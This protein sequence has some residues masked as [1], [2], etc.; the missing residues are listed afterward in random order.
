M[1]GKMGR[2]V[3]VLCVL[4]ACLSLASA[5]R[6]QSSFPFELRAQVDKYTYTISNNASLTLNADGV[7]AP[8]SVRVT[9][10]YRGSSTVTIPWTPQLTGSAE[11][12]IASFGSV[13]LVVNPSESFSFEVRFVP[14]SSTQSAAQ[15]S[16]AYVE[17]A[18]QAGG[19]AV[20]GNIALGLAGTA[21][22]LSVYYYLQTELNVIPLSP[23][24]KLQ[25]PPTLINSTAIATVVIANRG[26]GAGTIK[27][28]SVNATAFKPIGIPLMPA[29]VAAS[30]TIQ[31]AI[32]Y[33]PTQI[34]TDTGTLEVG[35]ADRTIQVTLEGSCIAEKFLYKYE[36]GGVVSTVLPSEAVLFSPLQVGQTSRLGFTV[37]NAGTSAGTVT[38][39]GVADTQG[40]FKLADAP[41]LPL[42]LQPG[43][44]ISF[45][46]QFAPAVPG[47]ATASLWIDAQQF[48]VS[49]FGTPPPPL[50]TFRFI[51]P[52]GAVGPAQQISIGL[53]LD[54]TYTL[55][56]KGTLT[57][58][59]NPEAFSADPAVQFASGGR[60]VSFTIPANTD[61][62]VFPSG[63]MEIKLQTGTVAG[64]ITIVP[65]F[66]T[67]AGLDLTPE[68][69]ERLTLT[70]PKVSPTLLQAAIAAKSQNSFT[71][72]VT[73][74]ATTR[75]LTQ[76]SLS[77]K[78]DSDVR[79]SGIEFT[80]NLASS[81]ATWFNSTASQ[82][83]G[84]QFVIVIPFTLSSDSTSITSPVNKLQSVT[85]TVSSEIGASG[86]LTA[87]FR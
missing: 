11:F 82:A 18:A 41:A 4:G 35:L 12:T 20:T 83:Y 10:T 87:A 32:R 79:F 19:T 60:T 38:S 76:M 46:I 16:I 9:A 23:G 7:G 37:I 30:G 75:S 17:A 74:Y 39:I 69:P 44:S 36:S 8:V 42:R 21:P 22:E 47:L 57:M 5:A 81:A 33:S 80:V 70:V 61:R 56:L 71:L 24:G 73:G 27:S 6:G 29:S 66:S 51:N 85:V 65:S 50:P 78:G 54:S 14:I 48:F 64:T 67:S 26:S 72:Q 86:T 84:G 53:S 52:Q 63:A 31:I 15:L 13:P 59:I 1:T 34:G 45:T 28:F 68:S 58:V 43:E 77:F 40:V 2:S 25:F 55:P 49:G 62:A 3:P